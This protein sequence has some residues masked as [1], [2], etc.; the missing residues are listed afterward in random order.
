MTVRYRLEDSN[1]K[2]M[3]FLMCLILIP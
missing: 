3:C 2:A 1:L